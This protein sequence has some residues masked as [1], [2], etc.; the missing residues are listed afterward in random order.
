MQLNILNDVVRDVG[1][2]I[3]EPGRYVARR[4]HTRD[5][6]P[7]KLH[8]DPALGYHLTTADKFAGLP[9]L[10]D[11]MRA[12]ARTRLAH[13]DRS[14]FDA[15]IESKSLKPFYFNLISRQDVVDN[16]GIMSFALNRELLAILADYYGMLPEL[17]HVA[18]FYSGFSTPFVPGETKPVGTQRF[19]WD[20]HDRRHVKVFCYLE[21]VTER[22]GPL[23]LLPA[24]KA[25]E[26]RQRTGRGLRTRPVKDDAE[27]F[28]HF[29][30]KDLVP[31]VG[32]AGTVAIV[33]TTRCLH[34]GSRCLDG[35]ARKTLVI[36]YAL[37]SQY[38]TTR[39]LDFQDLN[40]ATSPE[41]L[42]TFEANALNDLIFRLAPEYRPDARRP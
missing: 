35:G 22:D 41:L 40:V 26:F 39:T 34:A 38:S 10:L 3:A 11:Q 17:S 15:G 21:D 20:N 16:P 25:Y 6:P 4:R 30:P 18:L 24:A 14:A 5:L 31:I 8:I 37:F 42:P 27:M 36:H 2:I 29:S 23:T 32:P 28:E 12:L 9:A 13:L 7:P 1:R 19:H 33:D